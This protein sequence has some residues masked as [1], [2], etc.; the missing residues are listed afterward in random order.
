[1]TSPASAHTTPVKI[2]EHA[3]R[4]ICLISTA[5]AQRGGLEKGAKKSSP[6]ATTLRVKMAECARWTSRSRATTASVTG[7]GSTDRL[8]DWSSSTSQGVSRTRHPHPPKRF[9]PNK[10]YVGCS[11]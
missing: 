4:T 5:H 10:Q 11:I 8:A 2:M 7:H 1:M 6:N 3:S 9:N